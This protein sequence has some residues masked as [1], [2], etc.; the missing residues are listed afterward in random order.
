MGAAEGCMVTGPFHSLT[1][2][3]LHRSMQITYSAHAFVVLPLRRVQPTH[4]HNPFQW[5]GSVR[6]RNNN[7]TCT[8]GTRSAVSISTTHT[9]SAL[10][11]HQNE[12]SV[13]LVERNRL[14]GARDSTRDCGD[15][16]IRRAKG[17]HVT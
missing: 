9:I 2:Q 10:T 6:R 11:V 8:H 7:S 14:L 12:P 4:I 1:D 17:M 5:R 16:H 3:H 13:V 15:A